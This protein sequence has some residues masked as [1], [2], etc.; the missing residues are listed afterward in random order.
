[1][2]AQADPSLVGQVRDSAAAVGGVKRVDKL[3]VRKSGM[4]YLVDIHIQVRADQT[5]DEGHRISHLV[6]DELLK[7]FSNVRDVLVHLEPFP[8]T[9]ERV[10]S[11]PGSAEEARSGSRSEGT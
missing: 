3:F 9:H 4:E 5:V 1:M 10:E 7:R 6:K 8:N 2:D 11:V